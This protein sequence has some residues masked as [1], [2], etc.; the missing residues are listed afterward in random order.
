MLGPIQIEGA[1]PELVGGDLLLNESLV[2]F[3]V[4]KRLDDV[5]AVTPGGDIEM[6]RLEAGG[7]GVADQVQPIAAPALSVT[8]G[9]ERTIDQFLVSILRG[10]VDKIGDFLARRREAV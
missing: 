10:V 8:W 4:V 1:G 9:S 3:V 2:R 7:L 6:V 5:I